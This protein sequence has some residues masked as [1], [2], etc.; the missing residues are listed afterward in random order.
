M[1]KPVIR[2]EQAARLIQYI[3]DQ[4][5]EL[6]KPI[7]DPSPDLNKLGIPS[8][9]ALESIMGNLHD[10][11]IIKGNPA[12]GL[13]GTI[14]TAVD[15]TSKG[16]E[17]YELRAHDQEQV[18]LEQL[19]ALI[20]VGRKLSSPLA[21]VGES[22]MEPLTNALQTERTD[23]VTSALTII[24]HIAG[25]ESP[26]FKSIPQGHLDPDSLASNSS[27]I[28]AILGSLTSL[29]E[30]FDKGFLSSLESKLVANVHDDFL[31]QAE[32]L[33][34]SKYIVAATVLVG[35]ALENHLKR[36]A[37]ARLPASFPLPMTKQASIAFYNEKLKEQLVYDKPTWR[38]I[39]TVADRRNSAAH[40][41]MT[42]TAPDLASSHY[43]NA[44]EDIDFVRRFIANHPL[45]T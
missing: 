39:Q 40:G 21:T 23:F 32:Q 36:L 34:A 41:E 26:H 45:L 8:R 13:D 35:G 10:D 18:Y 43:K 20:E 30:A 3:G 29:R 44:E 14:W 24:K 7:G 16:W 42:A 25:T 17:K 2:S 33:L 6:G 11:G 5:N 19:D 4:V 9:E 1:T 12:P 31:M 37:T 15:L 27:V 38:R 28:P 22:I